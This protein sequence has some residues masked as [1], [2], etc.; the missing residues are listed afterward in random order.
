MHQ[1][2]HMYFI[3]AAESE[4]YPVRISYALLPKQAASSHFHFHL[5]K[6]NFIRREKK[7]CNISNGKIRII[8]LRHKS[9][10]WWRWVHILLSQ[11]ENS[12]NCNVNPLRK[13]FLLA[14][15]RCALCLYLLYTFN[16][17]YI[18]SLF[19]KEKKF[20]LHACIVNSQVKVENI[21]ST[22]FTPLHN[23]TETIPWKK[24][25]FFC[26]EILVCTMLLVLLLLWF[27]SCNNAR[28]NTICVYRTNCLLWW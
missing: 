7:V 4:I 2:I 18:F 23:K 27:S 8:R 22:H 17:A 9:V 15:Q 13:A 1:S 6:E 11:S 16:I 26:T 12:K 20:P 28:K 14:L 19:K 21:A 24:V 5:S 3:R 25:F 10:A